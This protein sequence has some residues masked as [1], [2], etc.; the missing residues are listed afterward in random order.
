MKLNGI[1]G[2]GS[3]KVG[4]SV[5]AVSGGE[6]IVRQYNPN[7]SNPSTDAQVAQ[8]AKLKLMSQVAAAL[9]LI[10]AF[11]K[12]GLVSAR[13]QFIAANL[14]FVTFENNAAT[15]NLGEL[16]LTGSTVS[17]PEVI[18][19]AGSGNDVTVNL[20]SAAAAN[21]DAVF[22][23]AV[24]ETGDQR[25]EVVATTL[26]TTAGAD[27]TFDSF[28][29]GVSTDVFIYAYGL[30]GINK[31]AAVSYDDYISDFAQTE[32][33]LEVFQ[34]I[35]KTAGSKTKTSYVKFNV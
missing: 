12:K 16:T 27:R 2:K 28:L 35:L 8:R 18:A 1:F 20:G 6:Q 33:S 21:V 24:K 22:Y 9:A 26:Q 30:I 17:F 5:F 23:A 14:P 7:V 15:L 19:T 13:N 3:G 11:A 4:S 25:L 34:S 29:S 32:A 10:I 31:A